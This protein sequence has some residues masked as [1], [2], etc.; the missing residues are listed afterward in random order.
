[1]NNL[2]ITLDYETAEV[3]EDG[4]TTAS[5]RAWR[6]N[7]RILS[8][9]F[10][11]EIDGKMISKFIVGE[12]E[13]ARYIV[14]YVGARPVIAHN[15]Q[16]E[17]MVT[18]CRFPLLFVN[19]YADTMRMA[20]VYDNGG[21]DDEFEFIFNEDALLDAADGMKKPVKKF[22]SNQGLGLV[23]CAARILGE[24]TSHKEPAHKWLRDNKGIK[25]GQEG[26]HLD[27]LPPELLEAY[28]VADTETTYR[29]Y[30]TCRDYFS[31]INYDWRFDHELYL[32]TAKEVTNATIRGVR[33]DRP[34]LAASIATITQQIADI[35]KAFR[36]RFDSVIKAVERARLE[37]WVNKVK[38]G[39]GREKRHTKWLEKDP[40]A[41]KEVVFNIGSNKQLEALF[42]GQ[43]K[44][45]PH[46]FTAK[47]Q[48][49]FKSSM[50]DQWQEGGLLLKT[51]RK[52]L[53]V[54]KQC[55]ALYELSEYDGRWHLG[56][57]VAGAASGRLAGGSH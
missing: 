34:Y 7:F 13:V 31:H 12:D 48:P 23:K 10:T 29:L 55:E 39:K 33:V 46:F 1:M 6:D 51:R 4:T 37:T 15:I 52:R 36:E 56:L 16:F 5:I 47:G 22:V 21:S 54:L 3:H 53:I 14:N 38:T 17:M 27:K 2:P 28:N 24:Q 18:Q 30:T 35:E 41:L 49:S 32:N 42:V 57:K 11:E 50:L 9:A 40:K 20:Q 43:L 19:W 26:K 45:V 8:C 44:L 25:K